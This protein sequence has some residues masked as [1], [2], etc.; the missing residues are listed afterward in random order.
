MP[1]PLLRVQDLSVSFPNQN[2]LVR[3][4][5]GVNYEVHEGEFLGIVGESGS[6]KSVSSMAVMGLLPS[7]A[8]IEG[9]ITYRG[10]SLLHKS[11]RELSDL[12]GREISMI[13]QDP[14]SALTPVYTIG[15]QIEE[16]LTLHNKNVSADALHKRAVELLKIVGIPGAERRVKAFPHE[17]SGG[18]RQRAMIAIAMAN[19]PQLIIADEPTTALDVTIQAQI[20]EVLQKAKEVTDAAVVLI[21]HDLG[22]VAGNVDRVAVMYAGKLVEKGDV[23]EVFAQPR[24]PYTMGLLRSVPNMLTAGKERLVPLEGRPPSPASLPKGCPF[25]DRCPAA[26]DICC[27]EEPELLGFEDVPGRTAAC[28][29]AG[30]IAAGTLTSADIF[31]R[32]EYVPHAIEDSDALAPIVEAEGLVRHF[33]L[34]KGSVFRRQVGAVKAVDGVDFEIRPGQTLGLVGESG[35]GK[36]TTALEI[37]ELVK[38]QAGRLVVD[39]T[40]V[41]TLTAKQRLA[42]RRHVQIV[43]QDPMAALDPRMPVGELIAEPLTVQGVP[44]AERHRKVRELLERVGL[45][46]SMAD[47]YPH[48][49]SGGQ[50]QRIGIARALITEPKLLVLDEPVSALDVS[51]QA[52][53]INL[54]EDLRDELGLSYLFVAHDLAIVREISDYIAVMYLGRIVEYGPVKDVFE[55]PKHPYTRALMSAVPVPDPATERSRQRI[56]LQGDLPSPTE[57]ITG[58]NFA[59]RCPLRPLLSDEQQSR[60]RTDDPAGVPHGASRVACHYADEISRLDNVDTSNLVTGA[61]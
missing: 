12:R 18:M 43:F 46:A 22:V 36:S 48:E 35:S 28:H 51:V 11:D 38:P 58:C 6:G 30:E 29:R 47:R 15:Q 50:R 19:D 33:P 31:P 9:S 24:M 13:F 39:G 44:K 52:G 3:A 17:F 23:D 32:P 55:H 7:S 26:I 57:T 20:L 37:M 42:M 56:L 61:Q 60:C 54:L 10:E 14:L 25:A 21:T 16:A 45:Y 2:G 4:V 1:E 27:Q 5:R 8:Q 34:M 40:D 53:V 59:S 41:S 49:F